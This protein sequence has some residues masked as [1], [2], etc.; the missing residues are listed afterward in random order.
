M[1]NETPA[2]AGRNRLH[3]TA[4]SVLPSVTAMH[5][6]AERDLQIATL[7]D[8]EDVGAFG[9]FGGGFLPQDSSTTT[10]TQGSHGYV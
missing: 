6:Y 1:L 3:D 9:A 5:E 4:R 10:T 8:V 2:R 7:G